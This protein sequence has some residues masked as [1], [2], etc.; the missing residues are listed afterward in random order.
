MPE[1][2]YTNRI[3]DIPWV[4][5]MSKLGI[6]MGSQYASITQSFEYARIHFDRVLNTSWVLNM[7]GFWIWKDY[8]YA[9]VLQNSKYATIWLNISE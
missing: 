2:A 7:P 6:W 1:C 4:L 5:N 9:K 8:E 3:L